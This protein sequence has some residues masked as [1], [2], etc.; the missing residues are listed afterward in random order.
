[1][2]SENVV[3]T[4]VL[5]IGG[6]IAGCFA[7]IKAREQGLNVTIVDKA[8]AG[9]SGAS[10]SSQIFWMVFNPEWGAD[11]DLLMNTFIKSGEY[12]NNREWCEI[13]LKDSLAIY[14][15]LVSWGVE[16]H[17]DWRERIH[18]FPPFTGIRLKFRKHAPVL[19]KQAE[20]VGVKIMD[21][22]MLTDLLKQ[23]GKVVGAIG[24]SYDTGDL[25][26]FKAKATVL[27]AGGSSYKPPQFAM[28]SITGDGEGM[29]YRAGAEITGKEF[30]STFPTIATYPLWGRSTWGYLNLFPRLTTDGEGNNAF[31][32]SD[33]LQPGP[34]GFRR[35]WK[36]N[37]EFLVHAGRGPILWDLAPAT[38]E[39]IRE[40]QGGEANS[41][42][43]PI[44]HER[45]GLDLSRRGKIL[46]AGGPAGYSLVGAS[47]VWV[48]NTKGATSLPGLYAAGDCGGTR[49]NGSFL[50]NPGLGTCPAAVTGRRAGAGAAEYALKTEKPIID[51]EE[52]ARLKKLVYAPAERNGGFSPRWVTQLLQNTVMPYFIVFV[53]H[54][55]RLQAAL[56]IVEFLRDHLVPKLMV[57]NAHELRL[58]HETRN[59]VLNA[60]MMLRASLFR[61]ESRGIH[62]REDY[63]RRDDPAW[64]AWTKVKEE[65]GRMKLL[66]EPVPKEWWPDLSKPYRERYDLRFPGEAVE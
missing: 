32:F 34:E 64:L 2:S 65:Q 17:P 35:E 31:P 58:A 59:M 26:I 11:F 63:P 53:K 43:R 21:R 66:K 16:F 47:G 22:I 38:D 36:L 49:Y 44:E 42:Y 55:E 50:T 13:I 45:I 19:R 48:I 56:T 37:W 15:D 62:Y 41:G 10:I 60:E 8:Y 7:A 14:H 6:G 33:Y 3:E 39:D 57:K 51:R 18:M 46:V 25:Y 30:L 54:G 52:L 4:D 1:M 5:V 27:T 23:D 61:T 20:K 24:F 12:I 9:K 40:A 28:W 29:A